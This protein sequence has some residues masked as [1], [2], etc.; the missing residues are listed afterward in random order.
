MEAYQLNQVD[1]DQKIHW[2]AFLNFA[3][4]AKKKS[5]KHRMKPV[6]SSFRKFFDYEKEIAKAKNKKKKTGR[7]D[8]IGK[9][10]KKG[11]A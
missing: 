6:Y 11:G 3:V 7:M 4:Q 9:I 2:Q 8:G 10:L 5:G 1:E